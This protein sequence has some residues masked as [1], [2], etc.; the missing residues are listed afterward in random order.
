[1]TKQA[2]APTELYRVQLQD[3]LPAIGSGLRWVYAREGHKW[4][5]VLCPFTVTTVK[6]RIEAWRAVKRER[7]ARSTYITNYMK[8]RLVSLNRAPTAFERTAL[9]VG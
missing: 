2:P 5:F 1:M 6:M 9:V 8:Q 3:E 4:A 7:V